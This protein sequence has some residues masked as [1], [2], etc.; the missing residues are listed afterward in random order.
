MNNKKI[1]IKGKQFNEWTVLYHVNG[2]YWRCECSCGKI[3][4]KTSY[5]LRYDKSKSC[6]HSRLIDLK[7]KQFGDIKVIKYIGDELWECVCKCGNIFNANGQHLR[8]NGVTRCKKCRYDSQ[9]S[10]MISKYGDFSSHRIN[11]PRQEWQVEVLSNP[12]KFK[13]W[14]LSLEHKPFI[15]EISDKLNTS[16]SSILKTLH[17]YGLEEYTLL[18][19]ELVHSSNVENDVFKYVCSLGDFKVLQNVRNII[20]PKELDIYI[21]EKKLAIEINGNYWHSD[22]YKDKYYHQQKTIDCVKKG[23]RLIHIFEYEWLSCKQSKLKD[24]LRGIICETTTIFG[25]NTTVREV[26]AAVAKEF[27]DDNHLQ[28]S[29]NASINIGLHYNNKLIA[30]FTFGVPRY[31]NEYQYELIRACYKQGIK[32]IG[33]SEKIFKYFI[34]KYN[35]SSIITYCDISKFTGNMYIRLGFKPIQPKPIT[36]PNYVWLNTDNNSILPRYKT[37]KHLLVK[38]GLGDTDR[39]EVEIMETLGYIRIYDCGNMKLEWKSNV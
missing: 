37:Q 18:G 30:L 12:D 27:E 39:T 13:E 10:D 5:A 26:S 14:M 4:D 21:P 2:Q 22:I 17:K 11:N 35:P 28:S 8:N 7:D 19:K 15:Y 25:R 20:A 34:N 38:Y 32:V 3:R 9:R 29:A 23:I 31:N 33:G 36:E 6:G 1:D 16:K 24:L